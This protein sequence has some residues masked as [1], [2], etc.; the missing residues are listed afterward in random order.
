SVSTSDN[1]DGSGETNFRAFLDLHVLSQYDLWNTDTGSTARIKSLAVP[2]TFLRNEGDSDATRILSGLIAFTNTVPAIVPANPL[3]AEAGMVGKLA[4]NLIGAFK[5]SDTDAVD[6][7][8]Q[9]SFGLSHNTSYCRATELHDGVGAEI[10]DFPRGTPSD[11][12]IKVSDIGKY[13]FYT[14]GQDV[15]PNIGFVTK[16]GSTCA[17]VAPANLT[18]LKNP[19]FIWL[20]Y[21]TCKD[22]VS[23][24]AAPV[25][26]QALFALNTKL[27][28][29]RAALALDVVP[30]HGLDTN[31]M[32]SA[33]KM[34]N[35]SSIAGKKREVSLLHGLALCQ[36]V[37]ITAKRCLSPRFRP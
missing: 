32:E 34:R 1:N 25:N 17:T 9:L 7:N 27:P 23:C 8:F 18:P 15:D 5:P 36:S 20:A 21:G 2:V 11:G 28:E 10:A 35:F 26:N 16:T 6:P 31:G 19:Q 37:G 29:V 24:P 33:V 12:I 14:T 4:T 13:C 22:N 3:T 30:L